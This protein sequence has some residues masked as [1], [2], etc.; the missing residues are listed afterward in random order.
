MSRMCSMCDCVWRGEISNAYL[1]LVL[2]KSGRTIAFRLL[3][4][5]D[6]YVELNSAKIE[7]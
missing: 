7:S 3:S 6:N 5:C 1:G 2:L 4:M